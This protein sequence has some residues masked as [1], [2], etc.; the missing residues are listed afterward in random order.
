MIRCVRLVLI[1]SLLNAGWASA[2]ELPR[3]ATLVAEQ[4]SELD[5]YAVPLGPVADGQFPLSAERGAVGRRVWQIPQTDLTALQLFETLRDQISETFGD[6]VFDCK[7]RTCGGF[8]FRFAVEVVE[9]PAMYVDLGNY[10]FATFRSS[11]TD[12]HATLMV[13][14]GGTT[15]YVQLIEVSATDEAGIDASVA[16]EP[17]APIG[18]LAADTEIGE[19]LTRLGATVLDDLVFGSGADALDDTLF[20]SLRQL[21]EFL[22]AN[23]NASVVLVGHTDAIGS[24]EANIDLSERRANAVRQR[25]IDQFGVQPERVEAQGVGYLAPRAENTTEDGRTINRRVEVVLTAPLQ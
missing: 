14:K 22:S 8:D 12:T 16:T 18:L 25:L 20:E 17:A 15:G 21:A 11:D 3:N 19:K 24:L 9:A 2:L 6:P 7:D 5:L 1:L 4:N 23:P 10:F 13:S